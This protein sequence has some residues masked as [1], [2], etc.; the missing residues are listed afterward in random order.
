[1]EAL[2]EKRGIKVEFTGSN[3]PQRI[4][5]VERRFLTDGERATAA[6]IA[7]GLN[8]S[9]RRKAWAEFAM[10][11]SVTTNSICNS[12]NDAPPDSLFYGKDSTLPEHMV[13]LGRVGYVS[14]DRTVKSKKF[15]TDSAN[16]VIMCG[17]ANNHSR[18]TYRLLKVKTNSVIQT[19]NVKWATWK[20]SQP[21]N[22]VPNQISLCR[23]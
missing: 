11:T 14:K 20:P 10:A 1:M 12:A 9:L 8:E 7:A 19:R 5:I 15:V 2:C 23:R 21:G 16:K 3:T 22:N 6:I 18:D 4:G 17:Y 13:E